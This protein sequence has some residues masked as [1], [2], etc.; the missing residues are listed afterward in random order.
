MQV[1]TWVNGK[2]APRASGSNSPLNALYL[3]EKFATIQYGDVGLTRCD[4]LYCPM[5]NSKGSP[6]GFFQFVNQ[7]QLIHFVPF[8][9]GA[10]AIMSG[11]DGASHQCSFTTVFTVLRPD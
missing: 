10:L 1:C 2:T 11:A 8:S 7:S 9:A 6:S 4:I 5:D 3:S